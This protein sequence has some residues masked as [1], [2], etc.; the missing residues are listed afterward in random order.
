ML[1]IF[2]QSDNGGCFLPTKMIQIS[3]LKAIKHQFKN[4]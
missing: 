2:L 1:E 4:S 3:I